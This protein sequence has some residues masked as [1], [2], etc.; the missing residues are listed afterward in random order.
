MSQAEGPGSYSM[1]PWELLHCVLQGYF[2]LTSWPQWGNSFLNVGLF[3]P[4]RL[5]RTCVYL[6]IPT[7][8]IQVFMLHLFLHNLDSFFSVSPVCLT[9]KGLT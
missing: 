2:V 8:R 9:P 1:G 3:R 7:H 5:G 4:Y 6:P